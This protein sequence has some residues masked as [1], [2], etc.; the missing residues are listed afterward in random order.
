MIGGAIYLAMLRLTNAIKP[1]DV[2]LMK[3]YLGPRFSVLVRPIE[4]LLVGPQP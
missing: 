2:R 4:T 1:E 3:E